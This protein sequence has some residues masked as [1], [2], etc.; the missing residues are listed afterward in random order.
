MMANGKLVKTLIYTDVTKYLEFKVG[1]DRHYVRPRHTADR[2]PGAGWEE[3]IT[4]GRGPAVEA[5][6]KP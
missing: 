3:A 1:D 2:R 4:R 5:P 6:P